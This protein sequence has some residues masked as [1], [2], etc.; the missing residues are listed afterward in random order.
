LFLL[1]VKLVSKNGVAENIQTYKHRRN[2]GEGVNTL[3]LFLYIRVVF[4]A[5]ALKKGK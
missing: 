3:P 5:T 4:L 1:P 2:F